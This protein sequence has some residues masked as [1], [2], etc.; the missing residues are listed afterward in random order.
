MAIVNLTDGMKFFESENGYDVKVLPSDIDNNFRD[1][2]NRIDERVG[3]EFVSD[4]IGTITKVNFNS[5]ETTDDTQTDLFNVVLKPKCTANIKI[6][7]TALQD[8]YST[9][10]IF[11][12]ELAVVIKDDGSVTIDADNNTDVVKDDDDWKFDV[13]STDDSSNPYLTLKVTGKADTNI[14]WY[15]KAEINGVYFK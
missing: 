1:L 5:L 9:E 8:D 10:W 4:T 11:N 12:R 6:T 15:A 2:A 13:S 7:G 3:K 14:V